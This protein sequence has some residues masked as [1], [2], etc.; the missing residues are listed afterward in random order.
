MSAQ[1][2][3]S[4]IP[5]T[6]PR[7]APAP[8]RKWTSQQLDAITRVGENLLVSAA[9][10][11]G[12]TSVLAER[13]V[14]LVCDAP[15][16]HRCNVNQLL[17]VTFTE[18]A[19]AE[20]KARIEDALRR[21]HNAAPDSPEKD[22]LRHQ[23]ALLEH[24][25]ISTLHSFC[26]RIL[27]QHFHR[28]KIDGAF[29]VLDGDEAA[30]LRQEVARELF[31]ERYDSA[32]S[33]NFCDLVDAF[34]DGSDKNLIRRV[35]LT[36]EMLRSLVDPH[37]WMRSAES[38]LTSAIDR[39][40]TDSILGREYLAIIEQRL[41]DLTREIEDARQR[42][43]RMSGFGAYGKHLADLAAI[44]GDWSS[45]LTN[46][47]YDALCDAVASAEIPKSPP[48]PSGALGKEAAKAL[49]DSV[50]KQFK[51]GPL[52]QALRFST[53]QWHEGLRSIV[54]H[55]KVFLELIAQFATRYKRAKDELRAVDFSDLERH[56]LDLLK[57]KDAKA[58]TAEQPLIR[59][60]SVART[61]QH[62]FK[63]VL[64]D[65]YQDINEVQDA[66]LRLLSHESSPTRDP[67]LF[68]V[69]DVKQSIYGFR[70]AE[71]ARFL[72]RQQR[73]R[74]GKD[75]GRV[76]DLQSNFRSRQPLLD[77]VNLVFQKLMTAD[78]ADINYDKSHELVAG[79]PFP[80]AEGLACFTGAPVE[81][82]LVHEIRGA[83]PSDSTGEND[84][85]E[86]L[87]RDAREALVIADRIRQ[88]M[89][90]AG[91]TRLN[92]SDRN[93]NL[94]PIDYR[95]IVILLRA[96]RRHADEYAAILRRCG[97][98]VYNATGVGFFDAIEVTDVLSLL[99]L[100]DNRRQDVPLAA[101]LRGPFS[102][103]ADPDDS[104]ARIRLAYPRNP[105][106]GEIPPFH[107][108]VFRYA[109][110]HDDELAARLREFLS[111][112]DHWREIARQRPIAELLWTLYD[113]TGFLAYCGGLENGSQRIANLLHLHERAQQ[114][115]A[116]SRQGLSRFITFLE[117]LRD[118]VDA[119]QASDL[120]EGE[121]V[122]RIMS[123]HKSKG[124]EFP[125]VFLGGLGKRFNLQSASGSILADRHAA[126]GM[127]AIHDAKRIRYP[128][129]ASVLVTQRLRRNLLA[130]E[131]RILYVAMTRARE[132]LIL[133]G[134]AKP[135]AREKSDHK[136][137]AHEGPLPPATVLC[138]STMLDWLL[139]ISSIAPT[140]LEQREHYPE[141]I[142]AL[143]SQ[144][145][146]ADPKREDLSK[147]A[148]LQPLSP[149]PAPHPQADAVQQRI[150]SKYSYQPFCSL[151]AAQSVTG[152]T[153]GSPVIAAPSPAA[154]TGF[155]VKLLQPRFTL[156]SV[157]LT[158]RTLSAA[159]RGTATHLLLEHLDFSQPCD[160]ANLRRQAARAVGCKLMLPAQADCIDFDALNWFL[161]TPVGQL[162]R[163]NSTGNKLLRELPFTF[164]VPPTQF[165]ATPSSDPLDS[166]M[167]RGRIDLLIPQSSAQ[168]AG[169]SLV[170]YKTDD[171][172]GDGTG[173]TLLARITLYKLQMD[174]YKDAVLR[175]TT[176]PVFSTHLVFLSARHIETF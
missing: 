11:S 18:A 142:D 99:R 155:S 176:R 159:E 133:V 60:S 75:N 37:G 35:V 132:H 148:S 69:G 103:L 82:H 168:G 74:D 94:R 145:Q 8:A 147:L 116:F 97:I 130:E 117:S 135:D 31:A 2:A 54:P 81:L 38:R 111:D 121:N 61:Y 57:E 87:E 58:T 139:P 80:T 123:V 71:P 127:S 106:T 105:T 77:I 7:A 134:T 154:S 17:V 136:W 22:R 165:I 157:T 33:K 153:K 143:Q 118:E 131:L 1:R 84:D 95:D 150:N 114:F 41:G 151:P 125:V 3:P 47:G 93:N 104:L 40:L 152:L 113:T 88:L 21:R 107:E 167:I 19:A 78:A 30:L 108:A 46:D 65:E 68:C 174:L 55:Q 36:Y 13:C 26:S 156:G 32:D 161:S 14:H 73:F 39:P 28:A 144:L 86:E 91:A 175:V 129:L 140:S 119:A 15:A 115:G 100:L 141:A 126:L 76:I 10:G 16:P 172:T 43:S 24:A 63:H 96:P 9:A 160:P 49:L 158:D 12:K 101:V 128:S 62:L 42:I 102:G 23:V 162:I 51:E 83:A 137:A 124:L 109:Q 171:V 25:S 122:V 85:A 52:A 138:A 120:G 92:V 112:L 20:M 66:I 59:P 4:A 29:R 27:R 64:V 169:W 56:T 50:K 5:A 72:F 164:A 6:S 98:P 45:I 53:E 149:P 146:A 67:N 173:A 170:D 48:I 110:E 89:G 34:G 163:N 70:L 44:A 166:V 90:H 79:L